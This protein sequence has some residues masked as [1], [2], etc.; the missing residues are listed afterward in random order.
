MS[1]LSAVPSRN[2]RKRFAALLVMPSS[3][4]ENS[5]ARPRS[6]RIPKIAVK[7]AAISTSSP[8]K[9]SSM[10]TI[11]GSPRR[12]RAHASRFLLPR[13]AS[14]ALLV[15]R[16][17]SSRP[18]IATRW[19]ILSV[20]TRGDR[21]ISPP[22]SLKWPRMDRPSTSASSSGT[23]AA[24]R[25]QP[26]DEVST[27][28]PSQRMEPESSRISPHSSLSS[29]DFPEP[30]GPTMAVMEPGRKS[31]LSPRRTWLA[32]KLFVIPRRLSIDVSVFSAGERVKRPPAVPGT[33]RGL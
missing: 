26:S 22:Q 32:P 13:E 1:P 27:G 18:N 28:R 29:V 2:S 30:F 9:G 16:S 12:A 31:A 33:R 20:T 17:A 25:F 8:E 23:G 15:A 3:W 14:S 11:H 7:D 24:A 4:Q 5:T 10:S 21:P 19:S 6:A